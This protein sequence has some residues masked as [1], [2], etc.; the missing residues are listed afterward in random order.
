MKSRRHETPSAAFSRIDFSL[1]FL[2]TKE[3]FESEK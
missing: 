3:S 1:F 2:Y